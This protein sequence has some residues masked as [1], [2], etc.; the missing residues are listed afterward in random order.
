[1]ETQQKKNPI[2]AA[3]VLLAVLLGLSIIALVGLLFYTHFA[4]GKP[5]S[6]AVPGN[7]I[8]TSAQAGRG[9]LTQ[10][11][12]V[13]LAADN[14][15]AQRAAAT[16]A[17]AQ[18]GTQISEEAKAKAQILELYKG[19]GADTVPFA[20]DNLFPGDTITQYYG[21]KIS[22]K[23]DVDLLF[24]PDVTEETKALG[25]VLHIKVANM[26]TGE[27]LFD[28]KFAEADGKEVSQ[29]IAA[30][31]AEES[32][33][34]FEVTVSLDQSVGNEYQAARLLAD[35]H[36]YAAQEE[37][38]IRPPQT[39]DIFMI[40]LGTVIAVSAALL[41]LLVVYK[42]RKEGGNRVR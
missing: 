20:V 42:R 13:P 38:L 10:L 26:E 27:V 11:A 1:M 33:S 32:I 18:S 6:A 25:G 9:S 7:V 14:I 5:A 28:G 23:E 16:N 34:Y 31:D 15:A 39:G 36:W 40:L 12:A 8:A 4:D 35:F 3:I 37:D 30:N 24:R 21:V 41:T 2:K 22:H 29:T 19:H 17:A